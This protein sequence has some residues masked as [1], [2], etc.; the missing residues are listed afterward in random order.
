M[1]WNQSV[2][3]LTIAA[4]FLV[5]FAA[6]GWCGALFGLP[7]LPGKSCDAGGSCA[8]GS[9]CLK[10]SVGRGPSY[11]QGD[12]GR[13]PGFN[14]R[15]IS[16]G[17]GYTNATQLKLD[18][19]DLGAFNFNFTWDHYYSF[20][21]RSAYYFGPPHP[22]LAPGDTIDSQFQTIFD[23][24]SL[25][26]NVISL[27]GVVGS[28]RAGLGCSST[29]IR[30]N[31]GSATP[32]RQRRWWYQKF[33]HV[34]AGLMEFLRS[35]F[36]DATWLEQSDRRFQASPQCRRS[37][38]RGQWNAVLG[39]GSISPSAQVQAW[40]GHWQM[41]NHRTTWPGTGLREVYGY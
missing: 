4:V 25:D 35:R 33:Q 11:V 32:T 10:V 41:G 27:L 3:R 18:Q 30:R 38:W 26:L 17:P 28:M 34:W 39:M 29:T 12:T 1:S 14:L 6:T 37:L 20:F 15:D 19:A 8:D 7:P 40:S 22:V 21:S 13:S 5:I 2:L 24:L 9:S 16:L 23:V 36:D 31:C